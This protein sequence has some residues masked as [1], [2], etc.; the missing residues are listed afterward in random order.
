MERKDFP[1]LSL[2]ISTIKHKATA[3]VILLACLILLP[4]AITTW[5]TP[6][7]KTIVTV[8]S[9]QHLGGMTP[10]SDGVDKSFEPSP[11]QNNP[12]FLEFVDALH[13]LQ[14]FEGRAFVDPILYASNRSIALTPTK[15]SNSPP[16]LTGPSSDRRVALIIG[17]SRYSYLESL[18][19][20]CN[21]TKKIA[22]NLI[23]LGF[24]VSLAENLSYDR[25]QQ[26][27]QQL[28]GK[29]TPQTTVLI[30]YSGHGVYLNGQTYLIPTDALLQ[31][32]NQLECQLINVQDIIQK[33]EQRQAQL[34]LFFIDTYPK[35]PIPQ[36]MQKLL[37]ESLDL[38][39]PSNG[40]ASADRPSAANG[41]NQGIL[42]AFSHGP[43]ENHEAIY[44]PSSPFAKAFIKWLD[45]PH[46]ELGDFLR[47]I[48]ED[49]K[50]QTDN[51]Q[52]PW[53]TGSIE[54]TFYFNKGAATASRPLFRVKPFL[55]DKDQICYP[56]SLEEEIYWVSLQR[57]HSL[58]AKEQGLRTYLQLYPNGKHKLEAE[59]MLA[60]GVSPNP[61]N[62]P[63]ATIKLPI[64]P[65]PPKNYDP[66]QGAT[67]SG[68]A[69]QNVL[70]KFIAALDDET[71]CRLQQ[72]LQ[73]L[74]YYH[75]PVPGPFGPQFFGA[76]YAYQQA[77]G[78]QATGYFTPAQLPIFFADA[79]TK[80]R[81]PCDPKAIVAPSAPSWYMAT[82][83]D[84]QLGYV[85]G[86]MANPDAPPEEKKDKNGK[87]DDKKDD[88]AEKAKEEAKAAAEKKPPAPPVILS[89]AS[90][91][92]ILDASRGIYSRTP[93]MDDPVPEAT[94]FLKPPGTP[95]WAT[96]PW[97]MTGR[98]CEKTVY[99]AALSS[100]IY[101]EPAVFAEIIG[102][103]KEGDMVA[104]SG[105]LDRQP[106]YQV[107]APNGK[108]GYVPE[109]ALIPFCGCE[110]CIATFRSFAYFDE[111]EKEKDAKQGHPC[112]S[113]LDCPPCPPWPGKPAEGMPEPKPVVQEEI[114][115]PPPP[116]C[117]PVIPS[118][119][120]TAPP[121]RLFE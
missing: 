35:P 80:R 104:M 14:S 91:K 105:K 1:S 47:R 64:V 74:G 56:V 59:M 8:Q 75:G 3:V 57:V 112:S 71:R 53:E 90:A 81:E 92:A 25:L 61:I 107:L 12:Q 43:T 69:D 18:P 54:G 9:H 41:K 99:R 5:H 101:D 87:A 23:R 72:D 48:R 65:E 39:G 102:K 4:L 82:T 113:L 103:F 42:I 70:Q 62:Q 33:I 38:F 98:D 111:I 26:A 10:S 116:V 60:K 117:P 40:N 24:D 100:R 49:V 58:T 19:Y 119:D 31:N 115:C 93:K 110:D 76:I 83:E 84:G 6:S 28:L 17:N 78:M 77:R 68:P 52:V 114:P 34:G 22:S 37:R 89:D 67:G 94:I 66:K 108:M 109:A 15:I 16:P 63:E 2:L 30:Y 45:I 27:I 50:A 96:L 13:Y 121:P 44:G 120:V 21:D 86:V 11:W 51:H 85:Y 7:S 97:V 118:R 32:T 79:A 55:D 20:P 106:W 36:A 88:A 29:I 73:I 46:L 95:S